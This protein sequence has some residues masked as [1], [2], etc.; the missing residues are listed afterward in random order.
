MLKVQVL[1]K[2]GNIKNE[3][4][5]AE[6]VFSHSVKE[7]LLHEVVTSYLANQRRGTASTKTRGEVSGSGRKLW[8]QKGTGRARVGSIRTP[9]WRKG[10]TTFGP[11]PRDYS[12][13][14]PKKAKRAALKSALALKFSENQMMV[15]DELNLAEP[16]TKEG[17]KLLESLKIDSALFVDKH[18]NLNLFRAM[19]NIPRVKAVDSSELNVYEIM[20]HK[21]LV[22][23]ERALEA[24][25]ERLK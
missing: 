23:S 17:T 8:R 1:D 9:L 15:L 14:M 22:F 3:I 19:R 20:K 12:I 24:L 25:M 4:K 5:L 7:P 16:K 2:S 11:K 18:E 6:E 13:D 10:G 21:W